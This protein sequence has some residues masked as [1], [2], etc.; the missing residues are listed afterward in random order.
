MAYDL[1]AMRDVALKI[2]QP[3]DAGEREYNIQTQIIQTI[4]DT[5]RLVTYLATFS[6]QSPRGI[7]QVLVFPLHGP[8]LS[9]RVQRMSIALRGLAALQL[10]QGLQSLHASG[11]V[12]RGKHTSRISPLVASSSSFDRPKYHEHAAGHALAW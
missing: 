3:G 1:E 11:T 8:T 2:I 9:Y 12:H 7:H 6:L 4:R 10:L 5:S